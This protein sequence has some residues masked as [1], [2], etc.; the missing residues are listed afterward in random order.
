[1]KKWAAFLSLFGSLSTLLCCA[2]PALFVALGL[3]GALAGLLD[4]VP[5]LVW[6]S[7]HKPGVFITAGV[8]LAIGG[9][10]QW[11][12]RYEPCP[13]DPALAQACHSAR[14][15]S[16]WIYGISVVLFAVGS[17]FAFAL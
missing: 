10:A 6:V 3:G 2:L 5:Q 1:M 8:L 11:R 7:H 4:T 16:A 13:S 14:R 9:Y 17:Y 15:I 12:A